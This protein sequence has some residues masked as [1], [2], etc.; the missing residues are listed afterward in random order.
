[1]MWVKGEVLACAS[2]LSVRISGNETSGVPNLMTYRGRETRS[3][4]QEEQ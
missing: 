1:M 2:I 3:G 4:K